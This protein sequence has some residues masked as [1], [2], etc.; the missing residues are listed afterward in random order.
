MKVKS[1]VVLVTAFALSGPALAWWHDSVDYFYDHKMEAMHK[2]HECEVDVMD[3]SPVDSRQR[4]VFS[5]ILRMSETHS[6]VP[7]NYG[8]TESEYLDG[9]DSVMRSSN[10]C[11]N[12]L[13]ALRKP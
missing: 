10:E 8:I 5:V 12:A 13:T 11:W 1:T 2:L 3:A 4:T 6:A 7:A 9:F